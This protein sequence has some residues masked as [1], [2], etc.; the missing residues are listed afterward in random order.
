MTALFAIF[1]NV[2]RLCIDTNFVDVSAAL[3][4]EGV[5]QATAAFFVFQLLVGYRAGMGF[6]GN[7]ASLVDCDFGV[8]CE[9]LAAIGEGAWWPIETLMRASRNSRSG[10]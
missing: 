4:I 8:C 10:I 7:C 9:L 2:A 5:A 3:D 1:E 6:Q